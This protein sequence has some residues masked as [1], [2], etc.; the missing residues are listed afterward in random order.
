MRPDPFLIGVALVFFGGGAL[1][2]FIFSGMQKRRYAWFQAHG[3][4]ITA[5]VTY[6]FQNRSLYSVS[7]K[8]EDPRTHKA[9]YFQSNGSVER[10]VYNYGDPLP[11]LIDPANPKRYLM[12]V[13][14]GELPLDKWLFKDRKNRAQ[15]Q[16]AAIEPAQPPES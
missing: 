14:P 7:A 8:W 6:V 16:T 5:T 11:V 2:A 3:E 9:Y 13:D 15:G 1:F 4:R 12:Y 10:L